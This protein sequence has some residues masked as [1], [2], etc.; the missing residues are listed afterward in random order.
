MA[1]DCSAAI[2][3]IDAARIPQFTAGLVGSLP[4]P[5]GADASGDG[6]V[7]S[8]D[9]ALVLQFVAGLIPSLPP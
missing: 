9:S 6:L 8:I 4:C 3:A 2:D 1:A 5:G 7:N